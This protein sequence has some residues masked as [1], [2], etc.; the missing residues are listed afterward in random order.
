M[1]RIIMLMTLTLSV[2]LLGLQ[3]AEAKR[4]GS[5]GSFGYSKNVAPK[6][7]GSKN[8]QTTK[9]AQPNAANPAAAGAAGA[10]AGAAKSG[11]SRWLGPL[12]GLAAG[13]LLAAMLFGDGFEGMAGMDFLLM[14]LLAVGAFMLFRRMRRGAPAQNAQAQPAY[15]GAEA[16]GQAPSHSQAGTQAETHTHQARSAHQDAPAYDPQAGGSIIGSALSDEAIKVPETPSWFD[17]EGFLANS[18]THFVA[19]QAAW[20]AS[21]VSEIR[22]YCT[23]E[24]FAI[25]GA[26]M[27]GMKPGE[28]VTVVETLDAEIAEMAIDGDYFYVSVRFSGFIKEDTNADAH[29]FSEIWHIRRL[30]SDS[31]AWQ[32]AGIQQEA[33]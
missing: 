9:P 14:G 5:G 10:A 16:A 32:I 20:D 7:F 22:D 28:N 13:G 26:E 8:T 21:D 6:Q 18:K 4:F 23:P 29:S 19:V 30:A 12:A 11:A 3:T 15:A 27:A 1:K 17:A 33:A 24:L 25:L 31:G 2:A